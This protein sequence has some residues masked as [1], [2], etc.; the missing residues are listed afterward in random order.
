MTIMPT[1]SR[2][3]HEERVQT[4]SWQHGNAGR[5][6][7]RKKGPTAIITTTT[8]IQ[9]ARVTN[10]ER[11]SCCPTSG[12]GTPSRHVNKHNDNNHQNLPISRTPTTSPIQRTNNANRTPRPYNTRMTPTISSQQSLIRQPLHTPEHD[13]PYHASPASTTTSHHEDTSPTSTNATTSSQS[14]H[15]TV[16]Q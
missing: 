10:L 14:I 15:Y 16:G 2:H 3:L 7:R 6:G 5:A 13:N 11:L 9:L 12:T 4:R 1:S 8:L